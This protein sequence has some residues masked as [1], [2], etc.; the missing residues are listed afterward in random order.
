MGIT[1]T[2]VAKEAAD[3]VITDDNF[4]IAAIMLGWPLPLGALQNRRSECRYP[5][6]V[7]HR[8]SARPMASGDT[9]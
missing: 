5:R 7:S 8:A 6:D 1:G 2:A 3:R 9:S 4:A